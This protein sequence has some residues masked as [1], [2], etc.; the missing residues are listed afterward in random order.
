MTLSSL[1]HEDVTQT[2]RLIEELPDGELILSKGDFSLTIRKG[3]AGASAT[4]APSAP[5]AEMAAAPAAMPMPEAAVIASTLP[6]SPF[7]AQAEAGHV[8][9][10]AP[11]LGCFYRA[12]SPKEPVLVEIGSRVAV[13]DTVCLI[14]VMKLFNTVAAETSGT[15]V[16]I[17]AE[18]GAMVDADAPLFTI[19]P[20]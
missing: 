2:L 18:N 5:A 17:H 19:K 4:P 15:I 3:I 10:H 7:P 9:L 11:M 6:A 16:A 14:E 1:T 20:D 13:G 12:S 8:V